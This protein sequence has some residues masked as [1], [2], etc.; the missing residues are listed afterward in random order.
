M[1]IK[2]KF[3]TGLAAAA[4]LITIGALAPQAAK[5]VYSSPVTVVNTNTQP[6]QGADVE[7]L[8]RIPYESTA[9]ASNCPAPGSAGA[10]FFNFAAV[11]TGYRL[12]VESLAGYFQ[13][14]PG[15]TA[16]PVGYIEDNAF[17]IKSAFTAPR[18]QIDLGGHTQ[19][20]FSYATRFYVD[21]GEGVF[22]VASAVWSNGNSEM[23]LSGYLE[24]CSITGC[25]AVQH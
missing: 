11:P 18:A 12:V 15:A 16:D 6:V 14:S 5:A 20:A 22:A 2:R 9:I 1:N 19:A 24:N 7:K 3:F 8:A 21:S 13:F 23:V 17:R 25:P 10:C 4:G